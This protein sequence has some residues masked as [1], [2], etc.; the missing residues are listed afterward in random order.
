MITTSILKFLNGVK[1][2]NNKAW[3]ETNRSLY[4]TSKQ[5]FLEEVDRVLQGISDFDKSFIN[6]SPKECVF[7]LNRDIRFSKEKHPYKTNYA[8]YFNPAGKKGAGA[9]FYMHIEPGKSF[10]AVGLWDPPAPHLAAI[11]Q[12]IDY[13]F[14]DWKKIINDKA[15]QKTF[16][17]GFHLSQRLVRPPKGYDETNPAIEY[18]KMKNFVASRQ[19]TDEEIVNKK[20]TRELVNTFKTGAKLNEF[21]NRAME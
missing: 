1:K 12:E 20:F 21:I 14:N 15:F 9:G 4:E 3:L 2:N 18:L 11:R 10:A 17:K 5:E 19:F 6:L 7:R 13:N 16:G 8:A